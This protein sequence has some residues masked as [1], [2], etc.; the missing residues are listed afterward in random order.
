MHGFSYVHIY[1]NLEELN[2]G[3]FFKVCH[4]WFCIYLLQLL[5]HPFITKYAHTSVDLA[6]FVQSVFDPTQKMKDLADVSQYT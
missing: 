6:A 3:F 4:F 2:K 5:S 1:L